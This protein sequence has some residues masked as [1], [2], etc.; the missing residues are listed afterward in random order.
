MFEQE[1]DGPSPYFRTVQFA[2]Q[3]HSSFSSYRKEKTS[4]LSTEATPD[5]YDGKETQI[6]PPAKHSTALEP[7]NLKLDVF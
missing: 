6:S 5:N 4:K 1:P 2:N 7:E 3:N